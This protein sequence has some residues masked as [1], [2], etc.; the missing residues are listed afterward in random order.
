VTGVWDLLTKP[1][2][3]FVSFCFVNDKL[4]GACLLFAAKLK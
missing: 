2:G 1:I 4:E 3:K